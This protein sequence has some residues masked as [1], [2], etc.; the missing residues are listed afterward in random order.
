MDS[1][2][3]KWRDNRLPVEAVRQNFVHGQVRGVSFLII[4]SPPILTRYEIQHWCIS[5]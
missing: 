4:P 2:Q 3:D 1:K 5:F